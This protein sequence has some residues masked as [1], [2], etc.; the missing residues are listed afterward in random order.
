MKALKKILLFALLI[1][2]VS[3][4]L[5]AE[6]DA[7]K[8][9]VRQVLLPREV[10]IGDQA[11]IQYSFISQVDFF[12]SLDPSQ[13]KNDT[14]VFSTELTEF[15][16]VTDLCTIRDFRLQRNGNSYTLFISFIPWQPGTI[17][18]DPFDLNR[19]CVESSVLQD[20]N[21]EPKAPFIID[22][23][24]IEIASLVEKMGITSQRPAIAPLLL[25]GTTYIIWMFI[26]L[27]VILI[28]AVAFILVKLA[29]IIANW[30]TVRE[31]IYQAKNSRTAR[32]RLKKLLSKNYSDDEFA[33]E[34]QKIVRTFLYK[35]YDYSFEAIPAGRIF[36]AVNR[37]TGGTM[38]EKQQSYIEEM[39]SMFRR[40]DYV[41][42][43]AG[44]ID[45]RLLPAE[46]HAAVFSINE[47]KG[48]V[49][50]MIEIINSMSEDNEED[51]ETDA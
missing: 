3:F 21:E 46:D 7:H 2:P 18:F 36:N 26:I 41:K 44:S 25:P 28:F 8:E 5:F 15:S 33:C 45:S 11:Q 24:A 13:I 19:I 51:K 47:K 43:A 4:S 1:C 42:F 16:S 31:L 32:R 35:K 49:D 34:W 6:D 14:V 12:A 30:K 23:S 29:A 40:C 38:S 10:F 20:Q 17:D 22:L 39:S 48:L 37:L 50:N 27:A 9:N